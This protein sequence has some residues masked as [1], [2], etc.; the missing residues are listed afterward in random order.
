MANKKAAAKVNKKAAAKASKIFKGGLSQLPYYIYAQRGEDYYAIPDNATQYVIKTAEFNLREKFNLNPIV[1]ELIGLEFVKQY[2]C[3]S[4]IL[5]FD[6]YY[7]TESYGKYYINFVTTGFRNAIELFD[8]N[9]IIGLSLPYLTLCKIIYQILDGIEYLYSIGVAHGDIKSENILINNNFDIQIIDLGIS[10]TEFSGYCILGPTPEPDLVHPTYFEIQNQGLNPITIYKEDE[11]KSPIKKQITGIDINWMNQKSYIEL[12]HINDIYATL[13][14]IKELFNGNIN[15][16]DRNKIDTKLV[17]VLDAWLTKIKKNPPT[18]EDIDITKIKTD[19]ISAMELTDEELNSIKKS[20]KKSPSQ[21]NG[22]EQIKSTIQASLDKLKKVLQRVDVYY[23]PS[24]Y[25][26]EVKD[27]ER[28]INE[29]DTK[30]VPYR[31]IMYSDTASQAEKEKAYADAKPLYTEKDKIKK[32]LFFPPVQET[33]MYKKL[34]RFGCGGQGC[35]DLAVDRFTTVLKLTR[36]GNNIMQEKITDQQI[37]DIFNLNK[38]DIRPDIAY[39]DVDNQIKK[40]S[41][42]EPKRSKVRSLQ[43]R[44]TL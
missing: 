7:F 35:S 22:P 44:P 40:L 37:N 15:W 30:I 28:Q 27:Y 26:D 20:V 36:D 32:R 18:Q 41:L 38:D 11:G 23:N 39:M 12:T 25:P 6:N 34:K 9:N 19:F 10:C 3:Q 21:S 14:T 17:P 5:C 8:F 42:G 1:N 24:D 2:G 16:S 29:V 13:M 31:M 43:R 4:N 33:P